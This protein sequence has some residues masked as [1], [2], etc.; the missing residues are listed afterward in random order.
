MSR[1]GM[2]SPRARHHTAA[3]KGECV[4]AR[5]CR[6]LVRGPGGEWQSE[7]RPAHGIRGGGEKLT[8]L[9]R[10][11]AAPWSWVTGESASRCGDRECAAGFCGG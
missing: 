4:R 10:G 1:I 6:E 2:R 8:R 9:R 3:S 11:A 7:Q 5:V